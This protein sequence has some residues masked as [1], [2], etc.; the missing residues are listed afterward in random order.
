[1]AHM[2][3]GRVVGCGESFKLRL[4]NRRRDPGLTTNRPR[5]EATDRSVPCEHYA[6]A[7]GFVKQR[8]SRC[9][10]SLNLNPIDPL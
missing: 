7:A 5:E 8:L 3:G 4:L 2:D 1:M 6:A 10:F 9:L